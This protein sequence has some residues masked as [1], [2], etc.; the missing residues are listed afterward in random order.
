MPLPTATSKNV[1][2]GLN[3][4]LGVTFILE[5]CAPKSSSVLDAILIVLAAAASFAALARQ[6]PMQNVLS[7]AIISALIGGVA[8]GLSACPNFSLPF[9]PIFFYPAAG[10]KISNF[11]PWTV[12]LVWVFAIF[13][14]RGVARLILLPWRKVKNYGVWLMGLTAVLAVAFDLALE[15]FAGHVKHFWLWQPTKIP[16]T[17]QGA[18][19]LN[20]AGWACVSLLIMLIITPLLIRK[21]PGGPNAPEFHPLVLWLGALLLFA[22]GPAEARLWWPVGVD[23]I[24]AGV[25]AFFAVRGGRW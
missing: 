14:A 11:V 20:F 12:P 4:L 25:T 23:V 8:H 24:I 18:T 13:N 15:S 10:G 22:I 7:V 6:L 5:I 19:P 17:W 9:G 16:F 21:Q 2:W 1:F 3:A